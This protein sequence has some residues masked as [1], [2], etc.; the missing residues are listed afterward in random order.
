M[1]RFIFILFYI[2]IHFFR[3]IPFVFLNLINYLVYIIL[4]Y[5]VRYRKYLVTNNLKQSFPE[6]SIQEIEQISKDF[7]K[8]NLAPIFVEGFKG[9]TMSEK[10]LSKRYVVKNPEILDDYF[11]KNQSLIALATHYTNWEWGIQAVGKQIKHKAAALYMPMTNTLIDEYVKKLRGKQNMELVPV[12]E[13]RAYFEKEKGKPVIYI[14]AADQCPSNIEKSYW[15][16]FLNQKTACLHGPESYAR[17]NRLPLVFFDVKR[18]KKGF[19]EMTIRKLADDISAYPKGEPTQKY[20][21]L[22]EKAIYENPSDWLWS[23]N[24][25]KHTFTE[26]K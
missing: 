10:Q 16:D 3:V 17:F 8:K 9:F 23:H 19:Y 25:W 18:I 22:L 1:N 20:M 12:K 5:I 11:S 6:K 7:Y 14:M 15:V 21:Q 24:R 13:T 26:K 2:G 4:F